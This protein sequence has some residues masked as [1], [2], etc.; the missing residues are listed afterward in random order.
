MLKRVCIRLYSPSAHFKCFWL[1]SQTCVKRPYLTI[2]ISLFSR[3]VVAYCCMK[4]VQKAATFIHAKSNHL[5]IAI[6]MSP[7]WMVA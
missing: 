4:V 3:Q 7:E 6:S 5:F 1:Y 2:P